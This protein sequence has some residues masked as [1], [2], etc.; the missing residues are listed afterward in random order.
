MM[1]IVMIEILVQM[2]LLALALTTWMLA[3]HPSCGVL[4]AHSCDSS[5]R[6]K[7][8]LDLFYY[9]SAWQEP[10]QMQAMKGFRR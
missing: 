5:L 3:C 10:L 4:T 9:C 7:R 6:T 8:S 2:L 1:K